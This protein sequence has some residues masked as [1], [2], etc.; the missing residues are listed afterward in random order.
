MTRLRLTHLAPMLAAGALVGC[1]PVEDAANSPDASIDAADVA[2]PAIVSSNPAHMGTKFSV[3]QPITVS[4]DEDVDPATVT[5]S[6]VTLTRWISQYSPNYPN[7]DLIGTSGPTGQPGTTINGTVAFD[8]VARRLTFTPAQ[9][10]AYNGNYTLTLTDIKDTHGNATSTTVEF[11]TYVN[12]AIRDARFNANTGATSY[13]DAFPTE[14]S[15]LTERW[16][17][18]FAGTDGI[19]FTSD[20]S[21]NVHIRYRYDAGVLIDE[22]NFGPGPDG[23]YNTADDV[24]NE[25]F[26]YGYDTQRQPTDRTLYGSPGPDGMWGTADDPIAILFSYSVAAGRTEGYV[27][28]YSPGTDGNWRTPDDRCTMYWQYEYDA[29]GRKTRELRR[30]CG[31]DQLPRTADDTFQQVRDYTYDSNGDLTH[32]GFRNGPGPD[33]M[34]LTADDSRSSI[35]RQDRDDNGLVIQTFNYS[36]AGPDAMWGTAD[37][38]INAHTRVTYDETTK[39]PILVVTYNGA[40]SDGMWG[41]ADDLVSGYTRTSYNGVGNRVDSKTYS[42][43]ADGMWFTADDRVTIDVNYNVSQ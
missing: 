41:T 29:D 36:G 35:V 43:G 10:L 30:G 13:Y 3:I 4:F 8:A 21:P 12:A 7:G 6:S 11:R 28:Y 14:A 37:D 31:T 40:G 5:A 24:P 27:Y 1:S 22:Y 32:T 23:V 16:L 42:I 18:F 25:Y 9:P 26:T 38:I 20:D 33:G 15:G 17:R 34:W 39:L 2:G 19:W